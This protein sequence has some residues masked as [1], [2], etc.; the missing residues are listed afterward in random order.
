M[1]KKRH[2][3]AFGAE[4]HAAAQ[5]LHDEP[6]AQHDRGRDIEHL[7]EKPQRDEHQHLGS[8][9]QQQIGA[10][11]PRNGAAGPTMGIVETAVNAAYST[12]NN[13]HRKKR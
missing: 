3:A 2:A 1:R 9:V 6:Q 13:P 7:A 11:D 12:R 8:G 5:D 10:Q 4:A